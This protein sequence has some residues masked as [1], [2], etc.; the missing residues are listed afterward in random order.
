MSTDAGRPAFYAAGR[1]TGGVGDWVTL[2]H[3][4]YT[5]WHLSYV[6]IGAA[7]A[8]GA[9]ADEAGRGRDLDLARLGGTLLAFLLALGVGAH[10]L[11]ELRGRPLRTGIPSRTLWTAAVG[12]IG[13]AM[14]MG[15]A[16][17][18]LRMLPFVIVGAVLA[19]GY[20]LELFGG[21][22]HNAVGFASAWGAFPVVVGG[23]AQHWTVPPAVLVGAVAASGIS[24]AQRTLS[25]PARMLRRRVS[26]VTVHV[27]FNGVGEDSGD[28]ER[29]YGR[30][31]LLA[32]LER[33]LKLLAW[34]VVAL[35]AALVLA[36]L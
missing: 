20:N 22:L 15:L 11:D 9:G 36:A 14:A 30:A 2:L 26:A 19:V 6:A 3:P 32:P 34:A 21:V 18:G 35:A 12:G 5:L 31:D 1:G 13:A 17:G 10:A 7:L 33:T 23:Y 4:P 16:D 27:T 24:L 8:S 25:T 29:V 28:G